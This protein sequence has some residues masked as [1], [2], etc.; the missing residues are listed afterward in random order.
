MAVGQEALLGYG[1]YIGV[2]R[3]ITYGTY[4]TGTAGLNFLS[5]SL[6]TTQEIKILEEVQNQRVNSNAIQLGKSIE[7]DIEFYWSP[8]SLASNYLLQNAFGGGPVITASATGDTAGAVSFEHQIDLSDFR[9]TYSSLSINMRKGDSVGSKV[10]EY[11][12]LRVDELSLKAELDAPL[13]ATAS[14][15]GKDSS[16]TTNSIAAQLD[17]LTS[18]QAPLSF[19]NG[20]FSIETS[21]GAISSSS[22]WHVQSFEFKISNNLKADKDSRRIG[23]NTLQV[24]PPGMANF[25]LM[26]TIRYDT[27][28]AYDAMINNTR[29]VGEFEFLGDTLTGSKLRESIKITMPNLRIADAGDPEIGGPDEVLTSQVKFLV[30]RDPTTSGYAVRAVVRN[31]TSTY[32]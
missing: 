18:A 14:L 13:V 26:A 28:T 9:S 11:C 25:E 20:R 3:E 31:A 5:C 29:L 23:A 27:S 21:T 22:F 30:M 8:K 2:G 24:L 16:A 10:F 32:A 15:I 4:V 6:K 19:V 1:S 17:T 12:G 7:G